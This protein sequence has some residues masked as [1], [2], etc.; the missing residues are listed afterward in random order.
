MAF[1]DKQRRSLAAKLRHQHVKTRSSQGTTISYV[2]GWHVIAEANRIFGYDCWD[3][4][5]LSPQCVWSE[6]KAGRSSAFYTTKVRVTVRAGGEVIM[7][8]GIGTGFGWASSPEAAHEIALKAAETDATKR[9]L[10]TFGNPFGL[11]LYDKDQAGVTRPSGSAATGKVVKL[12]LR[13]QDGNKVA[14]DTSAQ[15]VDAAISKVRDIESAEGLYAFWRRNRDVLAQVKTATPA[16]EAQLDAIIA[17][18]K[19]RMNTLKVEE[20]AEDVDHTSFKQGALA[21]PKGRRLRSKDH[22]KYVALQPCLICGRQPT[23][24]HHIRFAQRR[25]LGEKVSDEFTVPLCSVHHDGV[26]R[27]GDERTWWVAQAIDPLK[28]AEKLWARSSGREQITAARG[29]VA[30]ADPAAL[31]SE[32]TPADAKEAQLEKGLGHIGAPSS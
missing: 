13:D 26:H 15:L 21:F 30:E 18:L 31:V 10:A 28:V 4:R 24:A 16:G 27:V 7:R 12:I 25:G 2:E 22:L 11:A 1:T 6:N 32:L 9:A 17:A 8:E 20:T 3:R 5:T 14:F 19:A 29:S 23:H